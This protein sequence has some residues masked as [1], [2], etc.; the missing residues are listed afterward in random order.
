MKFVS[1]MNSLLTYLDFFQ[2]NVSL[3]LNRRYRISLLSGKVL[4]FGIIIFLI[5]NVVESSMIKKE[6]PIVIQQSFEDSEKPE[7]YLTAE[8]F[9]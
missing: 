6:N 9:G 4:S 3:K 5:Y 8:N 7:I 1:R 2:Q